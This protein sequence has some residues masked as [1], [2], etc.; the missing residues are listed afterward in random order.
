MKRKRFNESQI[1]KT[2]KSNK[3]GTK[4]S[5]IRRELGIEQTF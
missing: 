5:D 1:I 4:G 3:T 2:L